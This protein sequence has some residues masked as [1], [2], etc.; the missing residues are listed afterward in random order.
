MNRLNTL[1]FVM[2]LL[3]LACKENA[4]ENNEGPTVSNI[5]CS[6]SNFTLDP[7]DTVIFWI[8]ASDSAAAELGYKW[9]AEAG[10]FLSSFTRDSVRWRAPG[11]GGVYKIQ[12]EVSNNYDSTVKEASITVL[13]SSS[14]YVKIISPS[15]NDVLVQND[16][17]EY[18][19]ECGH[20]NGI[21]EVRFFIDSVLYHIP[22]AGNCNSSKI[23]VYSCTWQVNKETGVVELK[24]EAESCNHEAPTGSDSIL[25]KIAG[26]IAGKK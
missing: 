19:A 1:L 15:A 18:K 5:F 2:L 14:P 6:R 16:L 12:V 11:I 3:L 9:S 21:S 8:V 20:A 10:T 26:I 23:N 24:V 22:P 4:V 7:G 25:V 13:S 17:V